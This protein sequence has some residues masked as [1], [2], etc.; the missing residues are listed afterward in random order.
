MS[1]LP[2]KDSDL[3]KGRIVPSPLLPQCF[4]SADISSEKMDRWVD[5]GWMMGIWMNEWIDECTD[6]WLDR[7]MGGWLDGW[8]GR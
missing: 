6:G 4:T 2:R 8:I 5:D 7:W 3:H 1:S